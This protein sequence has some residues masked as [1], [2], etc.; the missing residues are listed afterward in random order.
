MACH[1]EQ[2]VLNPL[3]S[4]FVLSDCPLTLDDIVKQNLHMADFAFLAACKTATGGTELPNEVMHLAAGLQ[5]AGFKSQ[6]ASMWSVDDTEAHTLTNEV[7]KIL[8]GS[9]L[10]SSTHAALAL[11]EGVCLLRKHNVP[12][13]RWIPFIHIGI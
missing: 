1:G 9:N 3:D 5:L 11:H 2:M 13:L 4:Y 12:L 10:P 8:L 7:Y 6:I